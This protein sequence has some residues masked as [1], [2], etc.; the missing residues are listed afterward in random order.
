MP[1]F[2]ELVFKITRPRNTSTHGNK[3]KNGKTGYAE[4]YVSPEEAIE[5]HRELERLIDILFSIFMEVKK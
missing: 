5:G 1:D 4:M 3:G 2:V